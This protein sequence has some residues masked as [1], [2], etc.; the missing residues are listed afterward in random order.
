MGTHK[1]RITQA[2]RRKVDADGLG[3]LVSCED[4][5]SYREWRD[6]LA[7]LDEQIRKT[8]RAA[9]HVVLQTGDTGGPD[10]VVNIHRADPETLYQQQNE[11][12][13]ELPENAR[14]ESAR[15]SARQAFQGIS[16]KGFEEE[17]PEDSEQVMG[18]RIGAGALATIS[19]QIH[20]FL[21]EM[22]RL[23]QAEPDLSFWFAY[24]RDG[25]SDQF[26]RIY[27]VRA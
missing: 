15:N 25:F 27:G 16:R 22:E 19:D 6:R 8:L 3:Q 2:I 12:P 11:M 18:F 26:S 7:F 17:A 10:N 4:V 24:D 13:E 14:V 23:D 21:Q 9:L 5:E 20:A 1:A